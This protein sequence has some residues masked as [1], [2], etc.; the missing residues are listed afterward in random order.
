MLDICFH[1]Y[2]CILVSVSYDMTVKLF[3]EF[4]G[5]WDCIQT[6]TGHTDTVWCAAWCPDGAKI[7]TA[8]SDLW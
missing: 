7:A 2:D 4:D 1:P 6:L 8:G 5:E 3:K